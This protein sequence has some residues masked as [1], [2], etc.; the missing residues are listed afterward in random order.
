VHPGAVKTEI[1]RDKGKLSFTSN[2]LF[3]GIFKPLVKVIGKT[4]KQGAQTSI[5]CATSDDIPNH[6][7][8]YFD[9]CRVAQSSVEAQDEKSA[10]RLWEVSSKLVGLTTE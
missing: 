8:A 9:N 6:N 1:F 3:N 5:H 2:I 10:E 7:G 4:A